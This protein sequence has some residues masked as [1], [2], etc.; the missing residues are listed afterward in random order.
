M[1]PQVS[2]NSVTLKLG[3]GSLENFAEIRERDTYLS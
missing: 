3:T 1:Q 2:L